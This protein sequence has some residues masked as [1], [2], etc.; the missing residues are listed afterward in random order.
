MNA[1]SFSMPPDR[2]PAATKT[3][4]NPNQKMGNPRLYQIVRLEEILVTEVIQTARWLRPRVHGA[5]PEAF[6]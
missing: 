4:R 5:T 1:G 6:C 3:A 2:K